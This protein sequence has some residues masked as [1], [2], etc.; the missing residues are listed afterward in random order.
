MSLMLIHTHG[1]NTE[2]MVVATGLNGFAHLLLIYPCNLFF[3]YYRIFLLVLFFYR[4]L[5]TC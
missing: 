2:K 1:A 4:D 3:F 5:V